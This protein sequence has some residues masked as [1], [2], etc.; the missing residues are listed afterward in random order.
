MSP[1]TITH[2]AE[3]SSDAHLD[4]LRV[5]LHLRTQ[6]EL[7]ISLVTLVTDGLKQLATIPEHVDAA[8]AC[9]VEII[10]SD[11]TDHVIAVEPESI[12]WTYF[13]ANDGEHLFTGPASADALA[14]IITAAR[15]ATSS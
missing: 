8:G 15:S 13:D 1:S 12:T 14:W 9:R 3:L 11:E 10:I 6:S 5:S 7:P 4:L 2:T